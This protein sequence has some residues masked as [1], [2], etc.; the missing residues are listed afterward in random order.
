M[1][2]KKQPF[3]SIITVVLNKQKT[4]EK[5]IKSVLTQSYKNFEYIVIDGDSND[6]TVS[7]IKK[8]KKKISKIVTEKDKGIYDAMNKGM[9][10]CNGKYICIV[11]CGDTLTKNSLRLIKNYIKKNPSIDFVFGSVKKH[12]GIVHGYRPE[13]IHYSW[14][15]YSS[16]STGFFLKNSSA[17]KIG[18]YNLKYKYHADYDYFYRMIVK[19][20]MKGISTKK[21]EITGIFERGGF[22]SISPFRE[23]FFEELKIRYDNDQNILL[24]IFIAFYKFIRHFKKIIN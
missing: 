14:G 19:Y 20:K 5:T 23:L 11:N 3:F 2:N 9:K 7:L 15:F 18:I 16:H 21:N 8:Y 24:I 6:K 10:L 4:I 17:K 12:W 22:S 13:K 1:K